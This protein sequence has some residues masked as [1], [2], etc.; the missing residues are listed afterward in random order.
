MTA[1]HY[2][3]GQTAA[4]PLVVRDF[5]EH[6]LT[7][8]VIDYRRWRRA[9]PIPR[10]TAITAKQAAITTKPCTVKLFVPGSREV[11][12]VYITQT[13]PWTPSAWYREHMRQT[14]R[15]GWKR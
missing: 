6:P 8:E 3:G 5:G 14:F 1:A 7:G 4:T 11:G 9:A 10:S 12:G 2:H 13:L 15:N